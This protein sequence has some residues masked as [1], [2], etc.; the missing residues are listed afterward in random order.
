MTGIRA[1]ARHRGQCSTATA[2]HGRLGLML[3]RQRGQF[4]NIAARAGAA[5]S[6]SPITR[7]PLG[8]PGRASANSRAGGSAL[9]RTAARFGDRDARR[10]GRCA[11]A[12]PFLG[13]TPD[14]A[15]MPPL[16]GWRGALACPRTPVL[17]GRLNA[18]APRSHA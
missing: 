12:R 9:E 16:G 3:S 14:T 2:S 6:R 13:A 17:R 4:Q 10:C 15:R 18:R 11:T 1:R 5:A 8:A 7:R